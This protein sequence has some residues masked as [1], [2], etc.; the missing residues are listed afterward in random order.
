MRFMERL[1]E[2]T[3]AGVTD[4]QRRFRDIKFAR[5][6]QLCR[7]LHPKLPRVLRYGHAGGR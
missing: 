6:Q 1:A 2:V 3:Q 5:A 4:F 7:L